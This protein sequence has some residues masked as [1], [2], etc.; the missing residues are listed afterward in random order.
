V[1]DP[2]QSAA[3]RSFYSML[4]DSDNYGQHNYHQNKWP[5]MGDPKDSTKLSR[6]AIGKS[7]APS[8]AVPLLLDLRRPLYLSRHFQQICTAMVAES[9][10]GEDLT[11]LQWTTL[12]CIDRA[13]GLD[14]RRL[15]E[16]VGIVPV[17][18]GQVVDQLEA[19]GL[20]DRRMN[21][22][23]RRAR[24]LRLTA[25]A[26]KLRR[27]LIPKNLAANDRVL[28]PLAPPERELFLDLLVRVIR[29]NWAHTRPG[30]G[31]RKRGSC[32]SPSNKA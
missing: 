15:A 6:Q 28:A 2:G 17:N 26:A 23:D 18:A 24:E 21:G 13:P 11:P 12:A 25:R 20:V 9:L 7:A 4:T 19:M 22:A 30:A 3:E 32:Q 8:G 27:R 14:Q 16:A 31:R 5:K 1:T 10:L 29:G